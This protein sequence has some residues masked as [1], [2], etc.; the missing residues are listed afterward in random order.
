MNPWGRPRQSCTRRP[1]QRCNRN[2]SG[3]GG[4]RTRSHAV[5][6]HRNVL[7][8]KVVLSVVCTAVH[9]PPHPTPT[10]LEICVISPPTNTINIIIHNVQV[11]L[12]RVRLLL[13]LL[14]QSLLRCS[15]R[16]AAPHRLRLPRCLRSRSG[17]HCSRGSASIRDSAP[18]GASGNTG[19][20][21]IRETSCSGMPGSS[22]SGRSRRCRRGGRRRCRPGRVERLH[23]PRVSSKSSRL[24]FS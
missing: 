23:A 4:G 20:R 6:P 18:P 16:D 22:S 3:R 17:S 13:V 11:T 9:H 1:G 14:L 2:R 8:S 12:H 21:C 24:F 10:P 7:I 5:S 19:R 15:A